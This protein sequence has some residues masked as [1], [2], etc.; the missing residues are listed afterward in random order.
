MV[1]VNRWAG[2]LATTISVRVS[3]L[4]IEN[5][6]VRRIRLLLR[7]FLIV[8]LNKVLSVLRLF[9]SFVSAQ[10]CTNRIIVHLRWLDRVENV[11]TWHS[12]SVCPLAAVER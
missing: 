8:D 11:L 1:G 2:L 7:V 5:V 10:T 4:D 3:H 9:L 12:G 6:P